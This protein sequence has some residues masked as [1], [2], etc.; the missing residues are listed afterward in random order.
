MTEGQWQVLVLADLIRRV[1]KDEK[2]ELHVR[3]HGGT[4]RGPWKMHGTSILQVG[5]WYLD[6][7]K[8][9]AIKLG[10]PL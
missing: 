5:E 10:E 4:Y 9:E 2:F 6:L 3:I 8:I 1:G 7:N